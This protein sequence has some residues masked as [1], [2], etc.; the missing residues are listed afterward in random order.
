MFYFS[1][2]FFLLFVTFLSLF[3]G[4]FRWGGTPRDHAHACEDAWKKL[5]TFLKEHM[6]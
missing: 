3:I 2:S 6:T 5:L 1:F 4:I